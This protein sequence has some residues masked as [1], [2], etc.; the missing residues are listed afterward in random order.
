MNRDSKE[1]GGRKSIACK[2]KHQNCVSKQGER[3][4]SAQS[5]KMVIMMRI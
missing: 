3:V 2:T 1:N 4:Y 5:Q